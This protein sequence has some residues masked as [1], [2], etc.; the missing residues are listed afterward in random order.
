MKKH[1]VQLGLA[2]ALLALTAPS[3]ALTIGD[4][5]VKSA[6]GERFS[7]R[8]PLTL[9]AGEDVVQGCVRLDNLAGS[10]AGVPMLA[11]Y[12]LTV[13]PVQAGKSAVLLSTSAALTEPVVRIGLVIRCGQKTSSSREFIVNQ[14]L[15]DTT[16][17]K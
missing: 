7:A 10:N 8:V 14:K 2:A 3:M 16:K 1:V 12:A 6:Y 15:A 11:N 4:I 13:E 17:K 5:V 9:Q